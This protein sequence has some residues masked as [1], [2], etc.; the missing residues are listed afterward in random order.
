[1]YSSSG[2]GYYGGSYDR[3]YSGRY[4]GPGQYGNSDDSSTIGKIK[5][6]YWLTK[7]KIIKKLNRKE[8][9]HVVAGDADLDSKLEVFHSIDKTTLDLLKILEKYQDRICVL[10]G[11][12]NAMGR[13]LKSHSQTDKSRAG[14]MMA[15]VGKVQSYSSQQRLGIRTP[16]QRLFQEVET[17]RQ[18]AIADSAVTLQRM[19]KARTEYRAALL[20]MKDV[21]ENLDPD[22]HKQLE[23]FRT[24]QG[25]VRRTKTRFDK[26]KVDCIQKIDLLAASRCNMFSN[27]L[28]AYQ[29]AVITFLEK[30]SRALNAV[31]QA[32]YGYQPYEFSVIK[33]LADPSKKLLQQEA[34]KESEKTAESESQGK[35]T[36]NS[37]DLCDIDRL[38]AEIQEIGKGCRS[39]FRVGPKYYGDSDTAQETLV[40]SG[41][42]VVETNHAV[43]QDGLISLDEEDSESGPNE[44]KAVRSDS[45]ENMFNDL[46]EE[47]PPSADLATLDLLSNKPEANGLDFLTAESNN[48]MGD[49]LL[50]EDADNLTLLNEIMGTGPE[51][52]ANPDFLDMSQT[53]GL[54]PGMQQFPG[55]FPGAVPGQYPGAMPGPM[56][57]MS[58][59]Q[60]PTNMPGS[61]FHSF[62][63]QWNAHFGFS[64]DPMS[65]QQMAPGAQM[66]TG[67]HM[68]TQKLQSPPNYNA[69]MNSNPTNDNYQSFNSDIGAA[70]GNMSKASA[71]KK[72]LSAWYGMFAELDPLANPDA[73]GK[74]GKDDR[75]C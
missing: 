56:M 26:L 55:Q 39:P 40:G 20:W 36:P 18:R 45:L 19:E 68:D 37:Q 10:S 28:T 47:L 61:A 74:E 4:P 42:S 15:A 43:G 66:L 44:D 64:L 30:N 27:V 59:S 29:N 63:Q 2:G 5:E 21:S 58:A 50:A 52:S 25:Q 35:E 17:F 8:D 75:N 6:E 13:F 72:D 51:H 54:N 32:F 67:S 53:H 16:L 33:E 9:T 62:N 57:Q 24:V 34:E 48:D 3:Q 49:P 23:K 31:S 14:K 46:G 73:I 22:T 60:V 41:V 1:M 38:V 65:Q 11:E 71:P 7:Q 69:V 70:A 12:E